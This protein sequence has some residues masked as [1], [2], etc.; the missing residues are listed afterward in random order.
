M[1][2]AKRIEQEA[3]QAQQAA[4]QARAQLARALQEDAAVKS[5]VAA[6][7]GSGPASAA[8]TGGNGRGAGSSP[9]VL[10]RYAASLNDKISSCWKLPEVMAAS[11][12]LKTVV[13]LTVSKD[14][15]IDDIKIEK[16]SGDAL[17]DQSV[18]KAL[19]SA[20]PLPDFPALIREPKLEFELNFTPKG[21]T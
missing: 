4:A 19:R 2:E 13:A 1:A 9:A 12:G 6:V 8:G 10:N 7:H 3:Q 18:L 21:L 20:E 14:G 5:V 16:K 17:F 15:A 11:K